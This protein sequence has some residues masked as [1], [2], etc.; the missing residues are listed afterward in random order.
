MITYP[1]LI[2]S[3]LWLS[4]LIYLMIKNKSQSH[5]GVL[6]SLLFY[7]ILQIIYVAANFSD[8]L[9]LVHY[10]WLALFICLAIDYMTIDSNRS[11]LIRT[12]RNFA[13]VHDKYHSIIENT[14]IG[15]YVIDR[16]GT[17]G[18]ANFY[19]AKMLGYENSLDLI[20]KNIIDLTVE[21]YK[22]IAK[23]NIRL[24]I[25]GKKKTIS[26]ISKLVTKN[27]E[28]I[29]VEVNGSRTENG[30]VTITGSIKPIMEN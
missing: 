19:L 29:T 25:S 11:A 26:Y 14:P 24:R 10:A 27:G 16:Y 15:F 13:S 5:S 28:I 3:I 20:G 8:I 17:I 18:F 1:S 30:H 21:E 12:L 6:V 4:Y 23:E 2:V 7:V 22:D 9:F